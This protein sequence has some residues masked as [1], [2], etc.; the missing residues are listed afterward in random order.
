VKIPR[1]VGLVE[2]SDRRPMAER[3]NSWASIIGVCVMCALYKETRCRNATAENQ[4]WASS[5][6]WH[7][8]HFDWQSQRR[9][10]GA[11]LEY[12]TIGAEEICLISFRENTQA[13][14]K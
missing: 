3:E 12:L 13:S 5:C 9:L 7:L 10:Y 14:G 11:R 6:G 1:S 4:V 8:S 2:K